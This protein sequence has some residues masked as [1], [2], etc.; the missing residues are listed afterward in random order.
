MPASAPIASAAANPQ[1][2]S[3]GGVDELPAT[4]S[5]TVLMGVDRDSVGE[6]QGEHLHHPRHELA[7]RIGIQRT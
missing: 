1:V 6:I 5:G 7:V 4:Q 3:A 2:A